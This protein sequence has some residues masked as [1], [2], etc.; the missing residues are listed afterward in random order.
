MVVE[1]NSRLTTSYVALSE[2]LD[3]N[4]AE[5]IWNVFKNQLLDVNI[6]NAKPIAISL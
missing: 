6:K 1:I 3:L 2:S 4:V 5:L